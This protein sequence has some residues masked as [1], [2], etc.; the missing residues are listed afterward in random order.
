MSTHAL[1]TGGLCRDGSPDCAH[2]RS[3]TVDDEMSRPGH[4]R[5]L[6]RPDHLIWGSGSD[7][8]A[9]SGKFSST[10]GKF[11]PGRSKATV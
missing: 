10:S 9:F 3:Q 4:V 7:T 1:G 8:T 6:S 11:R 2:G 5:G